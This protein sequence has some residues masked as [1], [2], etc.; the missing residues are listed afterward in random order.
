MR[1]SSGGVPHHFGLRVNVIRCRGAVQRRDDERSGGGSGA[2]ELSLVEHVGIR[3]HALGQQHGVS[4]EH[5]PPFRVGLGEGDH[6]LSVVDAAG[7]L[8]YAVGAVG[9]GDR[10]GLVLAAGCVDLRRDVLP[11]DGGAVAPD[12]LRVDRVGDHLW[13]VTGQLDVGEVVGVDRG[14]SVR[15]RPGTRAA[16]STAAWRRRRPRCRRCADE[17]KFDGNSVSASRRLPP[18]CS[19]AGSCGLMSLVLPTSASPPPAELPVC[20]SSNRRWSERRPGRP[21]RS[22]GSSSDRL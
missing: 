19:V 8:L 20:R 6:G 17:L 7:H 2:F 3:G 11:G 18:C 21:Q 12:R 14:R 5:A 4:G 9:A 15:C 16:S 13:V 22:V 10:E 1:S